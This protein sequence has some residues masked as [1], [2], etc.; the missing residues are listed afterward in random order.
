MQLS[1][2]LFYFI[3]L[4]IFVHKV[5]NIYRLK[6]PKILEYTKASFGYKQ[7]IIPDFS[8]FFLWKSVKEFVVEF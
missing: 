1:V 3:L 6:N 7:R 5:L 4:Y 2:F 8:F